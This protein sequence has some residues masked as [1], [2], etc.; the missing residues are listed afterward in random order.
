MHYNDCRYGTCWT[1]ALKDL[2][3]GCKNLDDEVQSR[4]V[5]WSKII[6]SKKELVSLHCCP[7]FSNV[8]LLPFHLFRLALNFANCF[9]AKA[10]QSTFPCQ[11]NTPIEACLQEVRFLNYWLH[12]YL[13]CIIQVDNNAFTAYSNFFTHTQN[14]CY[15]LQS[16][17][18]IPTNSVT[19]YHPNILK[20]PLKIH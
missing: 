3:T 17:V 6:W 10:G 15:F 18:R 11:P 12:W 8:G 4:Q 9:L 19:L 20:H 16:Q 5:I 7:M 2:E 14:M 13:Y 1:H